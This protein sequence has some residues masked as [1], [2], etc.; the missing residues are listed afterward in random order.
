MRGWGGRDQWEEDWMKGGR[1][2]S[3]SKLILNEKSGEKGIRF[4]SEM[5]NRRLDNGR[6]GQP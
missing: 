3:G 6:N 2:T 1:E 4:G 5:G